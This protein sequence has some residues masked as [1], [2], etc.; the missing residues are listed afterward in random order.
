[1]RFYARGTLVSGLCVVVFHSGFPVACAITPGA[2]VEKVPLEMRLPSSLGDELILGRGDLVGVPEPPRASVT[3]SLALPADII[4]PPTPGERLAAEELRREKRARIQRGSLIELRVAAPGE[5]EVIVEAA[6]AAMDTEND[7]LLVS[8]D[9]ERLHYVPI[10]HIR[11]VTV[12]GERPSGHMGTGMLVGGLGAAA[13]TLAVGSVLI[14]TSDEGL[15]RGIVS[16]CTGIIG[17]TVT[18]AA[19]G[20]GA[21]VGAANAE[22]DRPR[23][24]HVIDSGSK[25]WVIENAPAGEPGQPRVE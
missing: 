8:Y 21:A 15:E 22:A 7:R 11:E 23:H 20:V 10:D 19:T 18:L 24:R 1:M 5:P 25:A 14:A 13:L 16:A 6:F 9:G 17:G 4:M 3:S 2:R 12:L